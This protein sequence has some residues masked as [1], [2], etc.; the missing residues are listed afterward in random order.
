MD[1]S[2]SELTTYQISADG[3]SV[4]LKVMGDRGDAHE[5]SFKL[6]ELG[7]LVITLPALI[8]TALRRQLRDASFRFTYPMGSWSIE[9]ASDPTA[10]IVTLRTKDGFGVSFTMAKRK[11]E[12]LGS[13]LF[14]ID[15]AQ[16]AILTH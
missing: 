4:A 5:L 7:S 12:D 8:E 15:T 11:A 14:A 10:V 9:Q 2:V 13:S 1:I 16:R 3:K 6:P